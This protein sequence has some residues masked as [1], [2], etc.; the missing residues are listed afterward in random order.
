MS[1]QAILTGDIVNSTLLHP[2]REKKLRRQLEEQF[3]AAGGAIEFYRG[4]SFQAWCK[5][6][7]AALQQA[8]MCRAAAI[9]LEGSRKKTSADIRI[10][11]GIGQVKLPL[12]P[13]SMAK[14]EAFLL[15]GRSFDSMA[16]AGQRLLLTTTEPM[17]NIAVTVIAE[18]ADAVFAGVSAKQAEVL[19]E[20]LQ[21][22]S[23]QAI[24]KKLR[25]TASTI[26]QR[27]QSARWPELQKLIQH[28]ETII[29]HLA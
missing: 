19:L 15:S 20:L 26:H 2:A 5:E 3:Q 21:G 24:A 1:L 29:K 9:S 6:P 18:Y 23:Q 12:G 10:S 11:I 17:A 4:D 25:K 8:M 14:G 28:F 22:S 27:Q 16:K 7:A 13:L